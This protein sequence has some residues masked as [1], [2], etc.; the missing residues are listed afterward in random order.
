MRLARSGPMSGVNSRTG[1]TGSSQNFS[2]ALS[3]V[4]LETCFRSGFCRHLSFPARHQSLPSSVDELTYLK[5][6]SRE[7]DPCNTDNLCDVFK[8]SGASCRRDYQSNHTER[9]WLMSRT[10]EPSMPNRKAPSRDAYGCLLSPEVICTLDADHRWGTLRR[11]SHGDQS[12]Q[13]ISYHDPRPRPSSRRW[14][15]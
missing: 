14:P 15:A 7:T 6:R 4:L 11:N 13:A 1:T 5:R 8:C 10:N 9:D 2:S 3:I 12:S